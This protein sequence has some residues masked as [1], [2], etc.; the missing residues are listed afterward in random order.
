M[1][2]GKISSQEKHD[3]M[4]RLKTAGLWKQ[5]W[6]RREE[7][8]TEG[9]LSADGSWRQMVR[10]YPPPEPDSPADPSGE[11]DEE[12]VHVDAC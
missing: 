5:A 9:D 8:R 6:Q 3:V 7:L 2:H 1:S 11:S 10:E 4:V 12:D